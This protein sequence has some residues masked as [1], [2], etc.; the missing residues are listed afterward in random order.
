M[1][2]GHFA[3]DCFYVPGQKTY[4]LIE[5]E[6]K[7]PPRVEELEEKPKKVSHPFSVTFE[8][9]IIQQFQST[10]VQLSLLINSI[11]KL[12]LI[13]SLLKG[14]N[15]KMRIMKEISLH[16]LARFV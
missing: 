1:I 3:Q 5:E 4:D 13:N 15:F 7:W 10:Y 2:P 11:F 9:M 12:L 14:A 6:F 8:A 16:L